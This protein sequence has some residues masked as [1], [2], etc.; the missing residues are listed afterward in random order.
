MRLAREDEVIE[1]IGPGRTIVAAPGCGTP[2]TLLEMLARGANRLPGTRLC[3]GL[4]LGDYPFLPAVEEGVLSYCTW[5]VMPAVRKLVADG[6]VPFYPVRA[7]QVPGLVRHLGADVAFIRVTPPDRHGFCNLGPSVSYPLPAVRDASLVVAELDETLPRTRGESA[8]HVS[9]IDVAVE[10]RSPMPEYPRAKP[11][12][13]SRTIADHILPLLPPR[14]TLQIGIG[15][16][17]E[18]LVEALRDQRVPDLRFV[19]MGVD[20]IADLHE[21]GLLEVDDMV[22]YPPV[23]TAELMGS[24]LLMDFAHENPVL[25]V[26]STPLGITASTLYTMDRFVSINSAIEIDRL[27]QV[28]AEWVGGKQLTGTGGSI[29]FTESALLSIGGMRI[30]AMTSTNLRDASPKIV[31]SLASDVPI[32]V[33]RHSVDYVVTEYG[34]ARLGFASTRERAE[35]LASVAHP[36]HRDAIL[37]RVRVA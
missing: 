30:I 26:Y 25:G 35:L 33:P 9:K 27:G 18:A 5:H 37:E 11:D 6:A 24:R 34:V 8:I 32:T 15:A 19:G 20:G 10:S 36:D 14:P 21:A 1:R 31:S 22:P 17:P 23:M 3:S 29:D 4:L 16:I 12:E 13:M 2:S 28:N 7:S